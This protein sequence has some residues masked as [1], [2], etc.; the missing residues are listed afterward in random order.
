VDE[1]NAENFGMGFLS[2]Q[3]ERIGRAKGELLQA[4]QART[5]HPTINTFDAK[6]ASVPS[7]LS[8]LKQLYTPRPS[9]LNLKS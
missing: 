3:K 5:A 8:I 1:I 7:T 2:N 6:T 4:V 9:F